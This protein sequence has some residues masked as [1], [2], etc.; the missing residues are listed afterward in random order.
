[1]DCLIIQFQEKKMGHKCSEFLYESLI[2]IAKGTCGT[3]FSLGRLLNIKLDYLLRTAPINKNN[4]AW[5]DHLIEEKR[6]IMSAPPD[7]PTNIHIVVAKYL[8]FNVQLTH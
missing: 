8:Y 6:S 5:P 7:E 4:L 1:M 3:F 2:M